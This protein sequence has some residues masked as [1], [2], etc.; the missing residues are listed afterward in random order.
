MSSKSQR[1]A[2]WAAAAALATATAGA[3][4]ASAASAT[5]AK[6]SAQSVAVAEPA[7]VKPP[8]SVTGLARDLGIGTGVAWRTLDE[9]ARSG[10]SRTPAA[11][12]TSPSR[13]R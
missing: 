9:L 2:V 6:Q 8:A 4:V 13:P 5:G 1:V 11:A 7:A 3:P 12:P 10:A